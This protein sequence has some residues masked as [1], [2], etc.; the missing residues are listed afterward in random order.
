MKE[1]VGAQLVIERYDKT[2]LLVIKGDKEY[3]IPYNDNMI[4]KIDIYNRKIYIKDIKGL[5]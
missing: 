5:F 1:V 2:C 3:L 4:E